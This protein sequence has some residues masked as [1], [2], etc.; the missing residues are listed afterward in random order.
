MYAIK[1]R[2]TSS[3]VGNWMMGKESFMVAARRISH[4]LV[5]ADK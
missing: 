3:A 4:V 5:L 2:R 1:T